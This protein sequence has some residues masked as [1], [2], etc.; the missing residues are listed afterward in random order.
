MKNKK[1]LVSMIGH[2]SEEKKEI[3]YWNFF[4]IQ[5][6]NFYKES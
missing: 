1:L 6:L 4:I 2:R 5:D 3:S